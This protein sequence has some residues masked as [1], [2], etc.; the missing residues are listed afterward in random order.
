MGVELFLQSLLI[1]ALVG[2]DQLYFQ[3]V[4]PKVTMEK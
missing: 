2:S 3:T 1:S 4:L